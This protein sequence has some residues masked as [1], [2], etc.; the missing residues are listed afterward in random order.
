MCYE[1]FLSSG[2]QYICLPYHFCKEV[3][4]NGYVQ[5]KEKRTKYNISDIFTK[6]TNVAT[7]KLL[8]P[9]VTGY[10]QISHKGDVGAEELTAKQQKEKDER[11]KRRSQTQAPTGMLP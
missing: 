6:P 7:T 1:D 11:D 9:Y 5:F 2:N 3:A 10:T 4:N 8:T